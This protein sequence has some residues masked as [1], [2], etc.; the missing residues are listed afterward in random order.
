MLIEMKIVKITV[1][2]YP[3]SVNPIRAKPPS[4]RNYSELIK[5]YCVATSAQQHGFDIDQEGKDSWRTKK[6]AP[7]RP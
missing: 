4:W 2:S 3:S 5:S 1:L 7:A 6:P